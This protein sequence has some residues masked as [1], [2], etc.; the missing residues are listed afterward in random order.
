[1]EDNLVADPFAIVA[2]RDGGVG[3][4][5]HLLYA[6]HEV[7]VE[8]HLLAVD[9]HKHELLQAVLAYLVAQGVDVGELY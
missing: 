8:F 9:F 3:I 4:G 6:V 5:S 7:G 1:M 2:I